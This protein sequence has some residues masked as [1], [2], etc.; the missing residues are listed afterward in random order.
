MKFIDS[1]LS[2]AYMAAN[3]LN[4]KSRSPIVDFDTSIAIQASFSQE[5]DNDF[6]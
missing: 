6:V 1:V 4:F 5:Y 3:E 2:T